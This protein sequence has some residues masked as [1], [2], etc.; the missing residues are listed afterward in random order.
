M[1]RKR[2]AL[3]H[4]QR[5]RKLPHQGRRGP[6]YRQ[7]R[8]LPLGFHAHVATGFLNVDFHIPAQ[9]ENFRDALGLH[10]DIGALVKMLCILLA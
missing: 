1:H 3:K 4:A 9:H 5:Q 10:V 6:G 2:A 7:V 8:P